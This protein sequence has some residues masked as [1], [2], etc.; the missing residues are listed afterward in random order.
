ML[1]FYHLLMLSEAFPSE[2]EMYVYDMHVPTLSPLL[3]H[4]SIWGIGVHS[5]TTPLL[6]YLPSLATH[7]KTDLAGSGSLTRKPCL[8]L[9]GASGFKAP[10]GV[11]WYRKPH[12]ELEV[13]LLV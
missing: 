5:L 8:R 11:F 12:L 1:N 9:Q 6:K 2:R 10:P 7:L 3:P 13:L 4:L